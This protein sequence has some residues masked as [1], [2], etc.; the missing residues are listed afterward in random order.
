MNDRALK[1]LEYYKIIE[2]LKNQAGSELG[3]NLCA[4]LKPMSDLEKIKTA[5]AETRDAL[6]RIYKK[7]SL[8]FNGVPDIR[9]AIKL[10]EVGSSLLASEL[11]KISSVL[12]AT[13]RV[14]SYGTTGEDTGE[15]SLAERFNLL[16]PLSPLNNEIQRCI[17]SEE[18]IADDASPGL[19]AVRR[20]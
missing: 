2:M 7:G 9:G 15:D 16:A 12:T 5:Q 11:L 6:S 17:I 14:K 20:Q 8:S 18:E 4:K 1:T 13:L 19:K 10:L 3:R